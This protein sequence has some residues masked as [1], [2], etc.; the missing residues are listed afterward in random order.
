MPLERARDAVAAWTGSA[1]LGEAQYVLLAITCAMVRKALVGDDAPATT[2]RAVLGRVE[3]LFRITD[4]A[5][6]RLW[7]RAAKEAVQADGYSETDAVILGDAEESSFEKR[8]NLA[9]FLYGGLYQG[10]AQ[11]VIFNEVFPLIFGQ[12]TDPLTVA[13]KVLCDSLFITPFLCLPVAY[14]VKR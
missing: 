2:A 1:D 7:K 8:R 11:E 4:T 6:C 14:I 9:F 5:P 12:G 3:A 10:M 13:S